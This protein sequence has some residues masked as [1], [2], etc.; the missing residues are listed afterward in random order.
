V[1]GVQTPTT[2]EKAESERER[3]ED[4]VRV[5]TPHHTREGREREGEAWRTGV[6]ARPDPYHTQEKA[7]REGR[8]YDSGAPDPAP[9]TREGR[10]REGEV[11][12]E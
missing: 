5:Q 4:W 1:A 12:G 6:R 2:Q 9:H 11:L 8:R 10:E 7:E 3:Y